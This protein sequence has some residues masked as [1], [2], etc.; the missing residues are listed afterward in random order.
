MTCISPPELDDE[1]LATYLDGTAE[2]RVLEHLRRCSY[3]R[4]RA[5][6]LAQW[7]VRLNSKLYRV[8]CPPALELGEY[9]LGLLSGAR[10][11][12]IAKHLAQCPNCAREVEQL[13]TFLREETNEPEPSM[14]QRMGEGL[15]SSLNDLIAVMT[16]QVMGRPAAGMAGVRGSGRGP[17]T[18]EA[19]D[20]HLILDMQPTPEGRGTLL[21]QLANEDIETWTGAEVE[22]WQADEPHRTTNIDD[23]GTFRLEGVLAQRAELMI[24]SSSGRAI[25]VPDVD[26][27]T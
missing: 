25:S 27:S 13:Q 23:L 16:G 21:G 26:L 20:I 19:G 11:M 17:V 9:Y 2:N 15:Q 14:G 22:L 1:A 12:A 5:Q 3:C 6:G 10:A 18:V 4:A 7:Q 8:T 24:T